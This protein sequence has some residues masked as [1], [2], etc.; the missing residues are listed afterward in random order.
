MTTKFNASRR[1]EWHPAEWVTL[2]LFIAFLS[3]LIFW[4]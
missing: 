3:A 1:I 4:S 2:L